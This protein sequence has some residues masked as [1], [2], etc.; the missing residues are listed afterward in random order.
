M[1]ILDREAPIH[2]VEPA[3]WSSRETDTWHRIARHP[4]ERADHGLDFTRRLARDRG[5]SLAYARGGVEAYRRFCFLAVT[6]GVEV[7]PSEEVD[8]VWHQHLTYPRDYW[9]VWC[10]GVL[11]TPLH[12][13]PT[14]GG[15]AADARD[16]AQYAETLA[17][18]EAWSGPADP[19]YWPATHRRFRRRARFRVVDRDGALILPWRGWIGGVRAGAGLGLAG[20]LFLQDATPPRAAGT[21]LPLNPFDWPAQPFLILYGGLCLAALATVVAL[22]Q[23]KRRPGR[24]RPD[25]DPRADAVA[26]VAGDLDLLHLAWRAGGRG[27]AA[28]TMLA[29]FIDAGSARIIGVGAGIGLMRG[30]EIEVD[31]RGA[32]LLE[33]VAGF[34]GAVQGRYSDRRFVQ[35]IAPGLAA[36]EADLPPAA[37]RRSAQVARMHRRMAAVAFGL[38]K[39]AVGHA[40]DKP[41]GYLLALIAA[42]IVL[43]LV[44]AILTPP[45]TPL[46]GAALAH[47]RTR[48]RRAATAPQD[49]EVLFAFALSGAAILAGTHLAELGRLIRAQ[50]GGGG[51]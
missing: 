6:C 49:H 18:H 21:A 7:T 8:E 26:G 9:E 13:D 44:V 39:V 29:D 40:R 41:V 43:A 32:T 2:D 1:P 19:A 48:Y 27:R 22:G 24:D 30:P 46:V 28:D 4:F 36:V 15:A 51:D 16:R 17:L 11:R 5:W 45:W 47:Y 12:H 14:W 31:S 23:A 38:I 34:R 35:D 37:S 25:A 33:P 20:S 3:R 50:A 42:T 10:A